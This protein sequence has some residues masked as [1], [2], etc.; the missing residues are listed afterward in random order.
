MAVG[1]GPTPDE[2]AFC[3]RASLGDGFTEAENRCLKEWKVWQSTLDP[4]P[5]LSARDRDLYHI[6][7]AVLR[8]HE[9]KSIPGAVLPGGAAGCEAGAASVWIEDLAAAGAGFLAAGAIRDAYRIIHYL[10]VT[11]HAD[12]HWPQSMSPG[13]D[14]R[15]DCGRLDETAL[16]LLLVD[17][18][19]REKAINE[20]DVS[21]LWPMMKRGASYL[22]RNGPAG[23]GDRREEDPGY[24]PATL[25]REIAALLAAADFAEMNGDPAV[26]GHL[27]E[28]ADA[29]NDGIERW[30]FVRYRVPE[31]AVGVS[32]Y[33]VE[34]VPSPAAH[35]PPGG[36]RARI[37]PHPE[38]AAYGVSTD[39][40]ELVRLGLR[41]PD[42]PRIEDTV[43][44]IDAVL[45][46]EL[47]QG[48]FWR[49]FTGDIYG[50]SVD[51]QES[52]RVWPVLGAERALYEL[53][54]GRRDA[55][56]RLRDTVAS[57]ARGSGMIPEQVPG[58]G[59]A[60]R[61]ELLPGWPL[62]RAHAAYLVLLRSLQDGGVFVR[63]P[64]TAER[65]LDLQTPPKHTLWRFNNRC[66]TAPAGRLLRIE[67]LVPAVIR[68]SADGWK[69]AR[70]SNTRNSGAGTYAADLST[71]T[72]TAGTAV[73]FTFYWPSANRWEGRN[74]A[75]RIGE[76]ETVR[77]E[78]ARFLR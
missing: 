29:W 62:V 65:Y 57:S 35:L 5:R 52:Q 33:Y 15:L 26:A 59:E 68:W 54:A 27:R 34:T 53:A 3:A 46:V 28:T 32:G 8:M 18:A 45:R 78:P 24:S 72:L 75:V 2:A 23:P 71:G 7:G 50:E 51:G 44:V 42:D 64:Q 66:A 20:A 17:L 73:E 1:C 12:G 67:T 58:P 77:V 11:Q 47:P 16:A 21:R 9:Q 55:A 39:V 56:E 13:G 30:T 10:Q 60:D 4:Q 69:T 49:R 41:A 43:K 63:P 76:P 70:E 37:V 40:L 6:S 19:R 61:G 25:A 36:R 74:F 31:E 22:M 48:P 38:D 14:A